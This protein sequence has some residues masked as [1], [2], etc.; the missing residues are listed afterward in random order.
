MRG[1]TLRRDGLLYDTFLFVRWGRVGGVAMIAVMLSVT[2]FVIKKFTSCLFFG[3]K[4][5]GGCSNVLESTRTRTRIVGGG[6]LLRMGRGFLGGGTSLRGRITRHG[7][8]V[9][10]TRGGLGRHR[11]MLGRHRRRVRHG[12]VRTR[13]IGRG[14]RTRLSVMSGGGRRLRRV[15]HRR[16]RGLRTVSKLSTRRTGRHVMR[17]LGRRTGARTRSCVGSVVSSTGLATDGRTGHVIVRDVRHITARATVRGSMAMF[18]VRS[19]RVGKHVVNHR[20]HGVHTLRTTANIRVIMSSA[21]RT[22]MLSTFSP[23]HH[24]VTHLTLR[25]LMASKHVRPTHVRRMITGMHGRMRRRVVRANGH[26]A[27]SLNVR[28]LRPRLVHVVNGVGCHSSCNR[29]LLRR[30][31]RATGL[32]TIVTSR[33]KLGPG[34]TG[35]TKLLRSVNGMPSRRPRLP[36]TL[37]NVGLTRGFGRGP[38]VYGTVNTRRSRIR[39]AD[40]LTPV[41][42]MYST[43]SK[44]HPKTHHRV[45]RTCVGHLGS[46]RRLTVSC[47]KIAGACTVRTNHRLHIVINTSG[48]SSGRAR[49]LSNRVTGGVRSRVACPNRIGV[50]IVHRAHTI[51]CTGWRRGEG[52]VRGEIGSC[53]PFSCFYAAAVALRGRELSI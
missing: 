5:G 47:P 9:R 24:R 1:F 22:V 36:R 35:H 10:R 26:A 46:L 18:R 51:D 6:G 42:R 33:L 37:C 8:G 15:R 45:M 7:R 29:G 4:L 19:S 39:V 48:V 30:T 13:T 34:G 25:R 52:W 31:H 16:V 53:S 23:I 32:Y 11:L 2:Y 50:A 38:S 43:V 49:G 44:T 28:N 40:L 21:P 27:V 3:R 12:G 14:L 41:M 20:N 17:S